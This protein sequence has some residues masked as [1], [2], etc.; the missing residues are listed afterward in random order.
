MGGGFRQLVGGAVEGMCQAEEGAGS[1][2]QVSWKRRISGSRMHTVGRGSGNSLQAVGLGA[3][4]GGGTGRRVGQRE[5]GTVVEVW[6]SD[7]M[8]VQLEEGEAVDHGVI[9]L[10]HPP[11]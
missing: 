1:E 3:V 8:V 4:G 9:L 10:F 7:M 11:N 2:G 5:S 6:G